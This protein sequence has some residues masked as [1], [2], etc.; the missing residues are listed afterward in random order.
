MGTRE[1]WTLQKHMH[2]PAFKW[3]HA[4]PVSWHF[5]SYCL[6]KCYLKKLLSISLDWT[7]EAIKALF[8]HTR[9][10]QSEWCGD[11][12]VYWLTRCMNV[13]VLCI[14]LCSCSRKDRCERADEPWRFASRVDQCVD[15]TVQPNNISVTM[16]EV[17]VRNSAFRPGLMIRGR[18]WICS[19]M[20]M[21]IP[22][23]NYN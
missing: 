4:L 23:F 12:T 8:R 10:V 3:G 18:G 20:F 1:S 5:E 22:V 13:C 19:Y 9:I 21:R 16:S 2:T 6:R 17:Q 11:I 7:Q 15:L 14:C